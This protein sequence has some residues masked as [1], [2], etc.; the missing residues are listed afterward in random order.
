MAALHV[1]PV[2]SARD[3]APVPKQGPVIAVA[4]HPFGLL[5]GAILARLLGSVRPD[6]KILASHMLRN[7]PGAAE[8]CIFVDPFGGS[9]AV[10]S[11]RKGLKES[12]ACFELERYLGRAGAAMFVKN[13][14][15][16]QQAAYP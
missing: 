11:N 3:L 13:G 10:R 4:N 8:H 16:P 9:G 14:T 2:I 5:E 12:I 1:P 6:V 15:V 7:L